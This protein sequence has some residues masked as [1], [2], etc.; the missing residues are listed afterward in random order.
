L[1]FFDKDPVDEDIVAVNGGGIPLFKG[2][3]L[4]GGVGVAGNFSPDLNAS[5]DFAELV[6]FLAA[7]QP[8]KTGV[9]PV[10]AFFTK[11]LRER[12]FIDGIRLPFVN[13]DVANLVR[14]KLPKAIKPDPAPTGEFIL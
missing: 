13:Q 5:N 4:V 11:D 1:H 9:L 7:F 2:N 6:A 12:V 14:G 10:P 8:K 3:T